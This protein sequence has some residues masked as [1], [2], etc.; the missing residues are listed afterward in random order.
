MYKNTYSV[1]K[2]GHK[3]KEPYVHPDTARIQELEAELKTEKEVSALH[4]KD[5]M[6]SEN[7]NIELKNKLLDI[8]KTVI[9]FLGE[10]IEW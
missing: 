8:K 3:K 7:E 9:D 4:L 6:A 2:L 1:Q 5:F 10:N